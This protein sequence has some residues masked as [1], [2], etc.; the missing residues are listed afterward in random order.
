MI[1]H[2]LY[3]MSMSYLIEFCFVYET[4]LCL[5]FCFCVILLLC[6]NGKL[7]HVI[8]PLTASNI[9]ASANQNVDYDAVALE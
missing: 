5:V 8:A 2:T 1:S 3:V 7:Y 6:H 4:C 9:S